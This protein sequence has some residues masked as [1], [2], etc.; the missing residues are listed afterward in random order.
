[1]PERVAFT[2]EQ[3]TMLITLYA[4]ALESRSARPILADPWAE[5]AVERIDHDFAKFKV[6]RQHQLTISL[7]AKK[8]D[9]WTR[10]FLDNNPC[11]TVLYLGC[12]LDSRVHRIDPPECIHWYDVDFPDVIELRRRL[13]PDRR[14]HYRMV[15]SPLEDMCWLEGVPT[16]QP[17][18]VMAEGVTMY[19]TRDLVKRILNRVVDHFPSGQVAFDAHDAG[20]VRWMDRRGMTVRE[21]GASFSWGID[22]PRDAILLEPRL[23][24]VA[25]SRT[26]DLPAY[27]ALPLWRRL[28][29]WLMDAVPMFRGLHRPLLYSFSALSA[30]R[31]ACRADDT[32]REQ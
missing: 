13:Y 8:F 17:A 32:L 18:L 25:C 5:A 2:R 3:E 15:A 16:D 7:R 27:R 20:L 6:G 29:F 28:S 12:G 26:V 31:R 21:T 24:F 10:V 1:M 23:E 30:V 22:S 4:R 14:G 11:A 19:L 9:D